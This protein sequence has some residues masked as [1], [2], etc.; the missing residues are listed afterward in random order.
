MA[1]RR[2]REPHGA[3]PRQRC[4]S[5]TCF[6]VAT[7]GLVYELLAGT[8]ASYLLGDSVT[9]FSLVIGLYLSAMGVGAWL[10]RVT[11]TSDLAR[12][13]RRGRARGRAGRRAVGAAPVPRVRA[14]RSSFQLV[15]FGIVFAIGTLVGLELPLLM[16]IL[17]GQ[18]EFKDLVSRVLT[19]DYIGALARR[20]CCSRSCSCRSS[21]SC[22]RRSSSG[23]ATRWSRCGARGC[24]ATAARRP[25]VG[26]ACAPRWSSSARA[27]RRAGRG[28]ALTTLGRGAS[29]T[30]TRSCYA[31]TD[32]VP[33]HRRHARAAPASSCS[34]TATC[35]SRRPTSTAT[36][37]R[38][39]TRR[40]SPPRRRPPRA[41][42]GP[43]R[44]RRPGAAR[45]ARAP[46]GRGRS[47]SSTSIRR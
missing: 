44:R 42:A 26:C 10:S 43:R 17:E 14:R 13:L 25:R 16:R 39:C 19:F 41:R 40:C 22:A 8:L 34:S 3:S 23:S 33:A 30:P 28:D 47:R 18:L 24:C 38:S 29:C 21:G 7:C 20:R 4:C 46:G 5:S 1:Q 11:S 9:Q 31:E 15:L 12:A 2:C 37:R 6:V 32:A 36:T 45:G 27:G 35:S